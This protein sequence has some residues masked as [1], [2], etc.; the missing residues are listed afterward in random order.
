MNATTNIDQGVFVTS[1][2]PEANMFRVSQIPL[3]QGFFLYADLQVIKE[4]TGRVI[5]QK[6]EDQVR[7][8]NCTACSAIT[9]QILSPIICKC[10]HKDLVKGDL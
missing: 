4:Y 3:H 10:Q 6:N 7:Q 8:A 5:L 1:K 9:C 2:M